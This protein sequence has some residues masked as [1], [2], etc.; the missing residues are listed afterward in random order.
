MTSHFTARK[1]YKGAEIL[2]EN[3]DQQVGKP[4][5][6][7]WK[8]LLQKVIPTGS[9]G[10]SK[11]QTAAIAHKMARRPSTHLSLESSCAA[12]EVLPWSLTS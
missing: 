11:G 1:K 3:L 5:I 6:S 9:A 7:D 8:Y 4:P 12:L 2:G 10:E